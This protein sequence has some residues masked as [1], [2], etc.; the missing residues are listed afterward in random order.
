MTFAKPILFNTQQLEIALQKGSIKQHSAL[1]WQVI[2]DDV[3]INGEH[4][5]LFTLKAT[6]QPTMLSTV[7]ELHYAHS[8]SQSQF[9]LQLFNKVNSTQRV[10]FVGK[11]LR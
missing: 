3:K 1:D 8:Q 7:S 2:F 11:I 4:F 6:Q 10:R 9:D 5:V